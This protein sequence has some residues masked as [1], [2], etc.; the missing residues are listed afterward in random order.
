VDAA[1]AN[2]ESFQQQDPTI[3]DCPYCN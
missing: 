3:P 1:C 2:Y